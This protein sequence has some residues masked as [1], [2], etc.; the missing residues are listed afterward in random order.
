MSSWRS[1]TVRHPAQLGL[2]RRSRIK[3]ASVHMQVRVSDKRICLP[4]L[5]TFTV[6]NVKLTVKIRPDLGNGG[7]VWPST[8]FLAD[9]LRNSI[10]LRGISIAELGAG[11]GLLGIWAATQGAHVVLTDLAEL[12]PLIT[13]NVLLNQDQISAGGGSV[14]VEA[15]LWGDKT[16]IPVSVSDSS[17]IVG[18]DL[19]H[20]IAFTLFDDDTR[21]LLC[22]TMWRLLQRSDKKIYLSY[23]VRT[24]Q[25]EAQFLLMIND[26]GL[27]AHQEK[28]LSYS[29][30][31]G[32]GVAAGSDFSFNTVGAC[33]NDCSGLSS[34]SMCF[35]TQS[36]TD[37]DSDMRDVVILAITRVFN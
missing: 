23:E 14:Q 3:K 6:G 7:L 22:Q 30:S 32:G 24:Q 19:V 16:E 21:S 17:V 26:V 18:S 15:L 33:A 10:S 4:M 27:R 28:K 13:E 11:T 35:T 12:V 2:S 5:R 20:W 8:F 9:H 37:L 25:R 1:L 34:E 29:P 31:D 36:S